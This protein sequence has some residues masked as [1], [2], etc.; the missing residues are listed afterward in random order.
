MGRKCRLGKVSTVWYKRHLKE[1]LLTYTALKVEN[2][3]TVKIDAKNKF[4]PKNWSINKKSPG[5]TQMKLKI[6]HNNFV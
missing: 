6:C 5:D 3:R 2:G 4:G 1:N